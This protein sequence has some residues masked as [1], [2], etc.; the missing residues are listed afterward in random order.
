[1]SVDDN[2][3]VRRASPTTPH[4]APDSGAMEDVVLQVRQHAPRSRCLLVTHMLTM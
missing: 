1:M 4:V 3:A 2:E